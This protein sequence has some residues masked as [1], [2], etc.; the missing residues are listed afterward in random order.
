MSGKTTDYVTEDNTNYGK[1]ATH[2]SNG[3]GTYHIVF[4]VIEAKR[5]FVAEIA[6]DAR[7]IYLV[8]RL[9]NVPDKGLAERIAGY[10]D[11]RVGAIRLERA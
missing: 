5:R 1:M 4:R 11:R 7:R 10:C 9:D 6:I 3:N 8:E 2:R